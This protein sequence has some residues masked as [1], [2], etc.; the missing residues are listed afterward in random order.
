MGEMLEKYDW[1]NNQKRTKKNVCHSATVLEVLF[2]K[3]FPLEGAEPQ[4]K[5]K[6][7]E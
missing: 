5:K 3:W 1:G 2:Q 6:Q 4:E 7:I